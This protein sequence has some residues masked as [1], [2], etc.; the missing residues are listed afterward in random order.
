LKKKTVYLSMSLIVLLS[1]ALF[2][3]IYFLH[4]QDKIKPLVASVDNSGPPKFLQSIYGDFD[5]PLGK[6]MDVAKIGEDI[7]VS[8]AKGRDIKVYDQ[9]GTLLNKIGKE[10][11]KKGQFAFPYG[12][13]GDKNGNLYV[14]DM[15]NGN[16]QIFDSKGKFIRYFKDSKEKGALTS[17]G[18]LRIFNDK[19][20]VTDIR[21]NKAFVFNLKGEKLLEIGG[22]GEKEGQFIAPNAITV[23]RDNQIY[24]T[25]S[26]NNR[27]QVFDK[28]GKFLKIINGSKGGKGSSI[29][30]N[31]RGVAVDTNGTVII[32][33]SLSHT[34][35]G[36]D[37]NGNKKFDIGGMGSENDKLNLP[38]GLFLDNHDTLFVTDTVN[39]RIAVFN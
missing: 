23:D 17:P 4:L 5:T 37:K 3:A 31:P 29:L 11:D 33:N 30:L 36:F 15:L 14:A 10:G 26:G 22:P 21:Q 39:Q 28:N 25:D 20:Y 8:D 18:G 34:I 38:N 7:Y 24:V 16:I 19:V 2:G 6:P 35:Y 12:I 27:V 9:S 32:V 1:V 13:S